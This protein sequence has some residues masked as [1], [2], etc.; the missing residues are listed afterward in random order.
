MQ[1]LLL[2]CIFICTHHSTPHHSN[3][4]SFQYSTWQYQQQYTT[5]RWQVDWNKP[6]YLGLIRDSAGFRYLQFPCC[7]FTNIFMQIR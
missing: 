4:H 3:K 2:K 5:E 7:A 1:T 6:S